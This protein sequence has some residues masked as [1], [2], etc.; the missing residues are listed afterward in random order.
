MNKHTN[1]IALKYSWKN[2][3]IHESSMFMAGTDQLSSND[4]I[5]HQTAGRKDQAVVNAGWH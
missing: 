1:R 4:I 3:V 5:I 2:I